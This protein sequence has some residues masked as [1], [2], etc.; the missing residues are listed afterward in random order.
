MPASSVAG[1]S[2]DSCRAPSTACG[3]ETCNANSPGSW[4]TRA[5]GASVSKAMHASGWSN[6][7]RASADR[8][9]GA[10]PR[11]SANGRSRQGVAAPPPDGTM[12][13]TRCR[14]IGRSLRCTSSACTPFATTRPASNAARSTRAPPRWKNAGSKRTAGACSALTDDTAAHASDAMAH[15]PRRRAASRRAARRLIAPRLRPPTSARCAPRRRPH[16]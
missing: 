1:S 14:P 10:M 11:A 3:M 8:R 16:R 5:S 13:R 7:R 9:A 12:K 4:W 2:A 15:A 6:A